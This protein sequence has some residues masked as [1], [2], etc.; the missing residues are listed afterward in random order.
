[1]QR[2]TEFPP[3]VCFCMC[4][5][6]AVVLVVVRSM[7]TR[8]A[9]R[10][11]ALQKQLCYNFFFCFFFKP[12]SDDNGHKEM[13]T[14]T[15]HDRKRTERGSERARASANLCKQHQQQSSRAAEPQRTSERASNREWVTILR[16]RKERESNRYL[17]LSLAL[18]LVF[19]QIQNTCACKRV[20]IKMRQMSILY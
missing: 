6:I 13:T 7:H 20:K 14:A 1:M 8:S 11:R 15:A 16:G 12:T 18:L 2:H 5:P 4:A 9:P 3:C 10:D 17:L 19:W